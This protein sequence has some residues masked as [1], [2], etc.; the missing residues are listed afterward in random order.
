MHIFI[1]FVKKAYP[2]YL[3]LTDPFAVSHQ[4]AVAC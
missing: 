4:C 3:F 2:G 1:M